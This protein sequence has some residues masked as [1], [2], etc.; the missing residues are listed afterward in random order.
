[1]RKFACCYAQGMYG[2]RQFRCHVA[3][4]GSE[5]EFY[6]VVERYFPQDRSVGP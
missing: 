4:V 1:M 3:K 6:D 5:S 2:A